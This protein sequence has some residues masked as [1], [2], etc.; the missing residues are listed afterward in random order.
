[1]QGRGGAGGWWEGLV[2]M[3]TQR[4]PKVD[5]KPR[6]GKPPSGHHDEHSLPR[7]VTIFRIDFQGADK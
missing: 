5:P 2:R 3:G 7:I 1:M 6:P 4:R